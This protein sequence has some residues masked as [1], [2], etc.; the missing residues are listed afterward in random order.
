MMEKS[1]KQDAELSRRGFLKTG[2]AG[3]LGGLA[4]MNF[5]GILRGDTYPGSVN[6]PEMDPR[7]IRICYNEN[8]LGPSP[9]AVT[10]MQNATTSSNLYPSWSNS[11]IRSALATQ[12][13][14]SGDNFIFGA[15]ASEI[16]HLAADAYLDPG[17]ELI[18]ADP[19]Y[20]QMAAEAAERGATVVEVPL[21]TDYKHDLTAM[22]AAINSNT[23]MIMITNPNNPT[24]TL[25]DP[26]EFQSF[27][28]NVPNDIMVVLDAAYTEFLSDPTYPDFTDYV[29]AGRKFLI[30]KTFSKVYGLAGARGGYG[31]ARAS[32]IETM[33]AF[34]ILASLGRVTEAGCVAAL[35]DTQHVTDTVTLNNQ[36]KA[37]LYS[38]FT[39]MGLDYIPSETNFMMVDCGRNSESV[40]NELNSQ[41]IYVRRGWGMDDWLRVSTGTM[42]DMA[43]FIAALEDILFGTPPPSVQDLTIEKAGSDARL[44]WS[45]PGEVDWYEIYRSQNPN[46]VP[47]QADSVGTTT[48]TTW[49]DPGAINNSDYYYYRIKSKRNSR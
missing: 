21:T 42:A 3:T 34:K 18:W 35:G 43:A 26:T 47:T 49:T 29:T 23:E 24:G 20:G 6:I 41:G 46:F 11:D 9:L 13:G 27:M 8:P 38:E 15:G 48:D 44:R 31:I 17:E 10:A 32:S 4:L 40:Y 39:R 28:S 45:V 19:S 25:L 16:I 2:M 22:L 7:S 1:K 37:Y 30:I 33:S 14:L 5:P 12:Y 36:A